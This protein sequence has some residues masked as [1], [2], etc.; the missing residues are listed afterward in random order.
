MNVVVH[1]PSTVDMK[2]ARIA[3][4]HGKFDVMQGESPLDA[5]VVCYNDHAENGENFESCFMTVDIATAAWDVSSF[6][7]TYNVNTN[8]VVKPEGL[9]AGA[10]M[11]S[12]SIKL[13][14]E[15]QDT[16]KFTFIYE[17]KAS[18]E[19]KKLS[20]GLK[21]YSSWLNA[22]NWNGGQ[23]SGM[24]NFRP[25][26]GQYAA[27]DYTNIQGAS[28]SGDKQWDF[29]FQNGNGPTIED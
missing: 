28:A 13:T 9:K 4:P 11:E 10:V 24:Y 2:S 15:S 21:Y 5:Y 16:S 18:G 26:T 14:M 3:V 22:D 12:E 25:I 17:D 6:K 8:L 20:M 1:N 27:E 29:Y 7:L 19:V 23:E